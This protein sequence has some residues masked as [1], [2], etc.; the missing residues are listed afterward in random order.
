[1]YEKYKIGEMKKLILFLAVVVITLVF[2]NQYKN[3]VIFNKSKP[4]AINS[5]VNT[6]PTNG[7]PEKV[8]LVA[9]NLKT[10]WSITFLPNNDILFTERD[11]SLKLISN[12]NIT[13]IEKI[14]DV[15]EYGEGG[16]MG[17]TLHPNF[18]KNKY[19][20][21]MYTYQGNG[22]NT[23]NRV[24]RYKYDNNS[25]SEKT[26]IIDNIPGA[27]YHN[28]GR[29]KFGPDGYLYVTTGDSLEPSLAQNT[30]SLAGKI[31]RVTDSGSAAPGNPFNN[32]IYSY[33]H[34]NPQG[35]T[36]DSTGRLWETEHGRSNPSGYDEVNIIQSGKNYGWP[37]IQGTEKRNGLEPPLA[38]SGNE[39]WAPGNAVFLDDS[40]FYTGL[41][42]EA[43]YELKIENGNALI[44]KHFLNEFGRIRDVVLGPD[45]LLYISTSNRDGRGNPSTGDDRILKIDPKQL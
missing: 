30:N 7:N 40:L 37:E 28:G 31:L 36:W 12:N 2:I 1:M 15:L 45:K 41:K 9:Q 20:Y 43:L 27:I 22:N 13:T 17:L 32:L 44:T 24:A 42:G 21:V 25:L 4:T 35:I 3:K 5:T 39:T 26:I 8:A 16:L 11:G 14:S 38:Q 23:K 34:R 10:P 19:L 6:N 18:S 29:I 33:G